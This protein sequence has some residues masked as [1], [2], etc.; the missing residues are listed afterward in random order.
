VGFEEGVHLS[1][2]G[3]EGVGTCGV[4]DAVGDEDGAYDALLAVEQDDGSADAAATVMACLPV[5]SGG[6]DG[7]QETVLGRNAAGG[8]L[9]GCGTAGQVSLSAEVGVVLGNEVVALVDDGMGAE[10]VSELVE[11]DGVDGLV[12]VDDGFYLVGYVWSLPSG[13]NGRVEE[14]EEGQYEEVGEEFAVHGVRCV[15]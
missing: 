12:V 6:D 15:W 3:A 9:E 13:G 5:A 2:V 7:W 8:G 1:A 4:D 11:L 10:V 14:G